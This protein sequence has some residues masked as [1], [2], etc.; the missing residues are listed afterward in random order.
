MRKETMLSQKC[1]V[2]NCYVP[3]KAV[4]TPAYKLSLILIVDR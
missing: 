3:L 1:I 2:L 4:L